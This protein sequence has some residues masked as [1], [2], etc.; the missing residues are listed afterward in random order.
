MQ[1]DNLKKRKKTNLK[2]KK[3]CFVIN[4]FFNFNCRIQLLKNSVSES[5]NFLSIYKKNV[6]KKL[7][8]I[9][10][11]IKKIMEPYALY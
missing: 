6:F 2:I 7:L 5:T 11:N 10:N 4:Y 3:F 8:K 9:Q 1:L